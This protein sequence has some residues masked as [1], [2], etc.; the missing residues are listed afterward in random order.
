MGGRPVVVRSS[1]KDAT[2]FVI[3]AREGFI[4]RAS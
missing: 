3:D 1:D 2:S 4:F